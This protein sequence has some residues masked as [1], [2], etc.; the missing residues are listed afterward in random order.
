MIIRNLLLVVSALLL[1]GCGFQ[2]MYGAGSN[3]GMLRSVI[4]DI[5]GHERADQVL[6]ESLR[7]QFGPRTQGG[8]YRLS[9][10]IFM[11]A[12]GLGVGADDIATRMA[13]SMQVLYTLTDA[14]TGE[15]V[16]QDAVR[17]EASF[18]LPAQPYA[19][20]IA[21][22]D[23]EERAARDAAQRISLRLARHFNRN[24]GS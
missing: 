23:A 21:R 13:L 5:P 2:P 15:I 6:A 9:A 12:S 17:S 1:V 11:S 22:R 24:G 3:A 7:D 8:D 18:D 10:E 20:E 19:A 16:L 14:Q 4:I